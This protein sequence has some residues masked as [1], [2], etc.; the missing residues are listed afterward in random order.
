MKSG[1]F[2]LALLFIAGTTRAWYLYLVCALLAAVFLVSVWMV[3][4]TGDLEDSLG[5]A[6][7]STA[8]MWLI[9]T[10]GM[11]A[12]VRELRKLRTPNVYRKANLVSGL[13]ALFTLVMP[14][15]LLVLSSD[16]ALQLSTTRHIFMTLAL[17]AASGM[18]YA[19]LP[20]T[21]VCAGLVFGAPAFVVFPSLEAQLTQTALWQSAWR[22]EAITLLA[23]F[24]VAWRCRAMIRSEKPAGLLWLSLAQMRVGASNLFMA[25]SQDPNAAYRMCPTWM[26]PSW[27][28]RA[29]ASLW[30]R[31]STLMGP[32]FAPGNL[33]QLLPVLA[34]IGGIGGLLL[35]FFVVERLLAERLPVRVQRM[36]L[37]TMVALIPIAFIMVLSPMTRT[38]AGRLRMIHR[39][40]SAD[41]A[42]LALLPGLGGGKTPLA[43]YSLVMF[44]KPLRMLAAIAAVP[45]VAAVML[46]HSTP[47]SLL[48][49]PVLIVSGFT[50]MEIARYLAVG[51]PCMQNIFLEAFASMAVM[52]PMSALVFVGARTPFISVRTSNAISH[53][54]IPAIVV[55]V[56]LAAIHGVRRAYATAGQ[57]P[58][59]FLDADERSVMTLS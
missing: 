5:V 30:N 47:W 28:T 50:V 37:D 25:A 17:G 21:L 3:R 58:H 32:P 45:G 27:R 56:W 8:L 26:F 12:T 43:N 29:G 23:L 22:I 7:I 10:V 2:R 38:F 48:L 18:L 13:V 24:I 14:T 15:A 52:I 39:P 57:L 53:V 51:R 59:P 19:T 11:L 4:R 55:I 44:G 6:A 36:F 46:V 40:Q 49:L 31:I 54:V 33:R 41:L 16:A 42:E 1:I 34:V 20:F 35:W 9:A